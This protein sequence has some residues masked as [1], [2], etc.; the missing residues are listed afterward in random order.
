MKSFINAMLGAAGLAILAIASGCTAASV[1]DAG[2][3]DESVEVAQGALSDDPKCF[4]R[5]W[6]VSSTKCVCPDVGVEGYTLECQANDCLQSDVLALNDQNEALRIRVRSSIEEGR[7]SAA[8]KPVEGS[9][10]A[11]NGYLYLDFNGEEVTTPAECMDTE[12]DLK[13]EPI[14]RRAWDGLDRSVSSAWA[15]DRWLDVPYA[16]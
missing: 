9:W 16:L 11:G 5:V 15:S 1:N 8:T 13:G 10:K 12:L 4:I 2:D 3:D 6:V 7:L 14:Y